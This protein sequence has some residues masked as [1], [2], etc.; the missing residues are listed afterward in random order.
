MFCHATVLPS[1]RFGFAVA[2]PAVSQVHVDQAEAGYRD[3][4]R[5][6]DRNNAEHFVTRRS[7][8][9]IKR[10]HGLAMGIG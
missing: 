3:A 9:R 1:N 6:F 8:G 10:E 4:M 7:W 2:G 5:P